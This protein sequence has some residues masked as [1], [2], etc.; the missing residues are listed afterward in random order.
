MKSPRTGF[1]VIYQWR[2]KS[3]M[4][5][6]FH[7]AWTA[8]TELLRHQRGA[9]GSR[10]HRSEHGTLV[11][12]AQWPDQA[13]WEQSCALHELDQDLSR[14]MLEAAEETWAPLLLAT[15]DDRLLPESEAAE[16]VR[17]G[18]TH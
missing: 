6:Q 16:P 14:R 15:L 12:Y 13:A 10:L 7:E 5:A 18:H 1:A 8:L 9:R 2:I 17:H 3:G 4:E 11:A